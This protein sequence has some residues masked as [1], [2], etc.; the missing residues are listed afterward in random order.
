MNKIISEFN[1]GSS[2]IYKKENGRIIK[3]LLLENGDEKYYDVLFFGDFKNN[4]AIIDNSEFIYYIDRKGE[5]I[6]KHNYT[7]G[8]C[9]SENRAVVFTREATILIDENGNEIKYFPDNPVIFDFSDGLALISSISDK[10]EKRTDGFIDYQGNMII[11]FIFEN[12]IPN[13]EDLLNTDQF[14]C[15]G[16]IRFKLNG[17]YGFIDKNINIIVEPIYEM[18][19]G[20]SEGLAAVSVNGRIGFIDTSGKLVINF[21]YENTVNFSE[22]IA[23]VCINGKWGAIDINENV[24]L[25]FKY[26]SMADCRSGEIPF[27]TNGKWGILGIDGQII[28]PPRFDYIYHKIDGVYRIVLHGKVGFTNLRNQL[29]LNTLPE[30]YEKYILN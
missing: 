27:C 5:I 3:G 26:D 29:I 23:P 11:P 6:T 1:N 8:S 22:G 2:L 14:Y 12:E 17:K 28:I 18:A 7:M 21:E 24:V 10:G 15:N 19:S 30:S 25:D 4:R 16:R 9:F 13:P 20:F